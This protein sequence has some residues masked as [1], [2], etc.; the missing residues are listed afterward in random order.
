MDLVLIAL[1][2]AG[3]SALTFVSG[4]GLGTLLLPA[5][6][7][8]LPVPQAVAATA[9]VH[10]LNNLLKGALLRNRADWPTV[11]RFGLPAVPAAIVGGWVLGKVAAPGAVVGAVLML[12]AVLELW[13][14]FHKLRAP[15][16]AMP[17]GGAL[18]GFLGGLTGQQGALRS[19]FLLR[20][21][22][23]PDRFIATGVMIAVLIDLARLGSYAAALPLPRG[24]E[25]LLIGTGTIAAL[26][27]STLM[28]RRIDKV[29]I[30][31]VRLMV[32]AMLFAVGLA[33]IMGWVGR[34]EGSPA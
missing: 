30:G 18:T 13:P 5:F 11:L 29:T 16:W 17:I 15:S 25:L 33:M 2:A 12:L 32:S 9:V 28:V 31:S 24:R 7:L 22:L 34:P 1:V 20:T 23:A 6:A 4:F 27:A 8:L 14:R 26:A 21:G 19:V 3:A 10:L